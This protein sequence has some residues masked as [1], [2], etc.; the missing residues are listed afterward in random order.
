VPEL[1]DFAAPNGTI[2]FHKVKAAGVAGVWLKAT[3]G[4][5]FDDA[6]Y[7]RNREAA[8]SAGLRV[9]AYH[10]GR[11]D[12]N[13]AKAEAEHF[14]KVVGRVGRRDLRP[15]LDLEQAGVYAHGQLETW[16]HAFSQELKALLGVYPLFYSYPD[17]IRRMACE[18]TIGSGLWIAD[19]GANDG[20]RHPTTAP[21]PWKGWVAHQYTSKGHIP[22][23]SIVVDRS[24][25]PRI[26]GVLAHP[27]LGMLP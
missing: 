5:T 26:Q 23:L 21:A 18:T 24:Y 4:R 27:V 16:S 20:K 11:P 6:A 25:A 10:F 7:V 15:V 9:G 8:L 1:V 2:P 19:Y 17:Y 13:P 14:A 12:N 22:G 3:E